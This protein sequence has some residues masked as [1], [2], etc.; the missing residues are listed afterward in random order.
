MKAK[1]KAMPVST[2]YVAELVVRGEAELAAQQMPELKAVP[3]IDAVAAAAGASACHRVL[4]GR[5]AGAG[6]PDAVNALVAFLS[7]PEAAAVLKA[8]GPRPAVI[9]QSR[10]NT[11]AANQPVMIAIIAVVMP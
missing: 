8:K 9:D 5:V 3:G 11:T 4:G 1:T 7:S 10:R 6:R 2:G